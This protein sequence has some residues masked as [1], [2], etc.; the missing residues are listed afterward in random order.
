[1]S[2]NF[3]LNYLYVRTYINIITISWD[4]FEILICSKKQL[5]SRTSRASNII[6]NDVCRLVTLTRES[7]TK[8]S[9]NVIFY[10]VT[11]IQNLPFILEEKNTHKSDLAGNNTVSINNI[12][13]L[14]IINNDERICRLVTLTKDSTTKEAADN[15]FLN[16]VSITQKLLFYLEEKA[17][18]KC[19]LAGNNNLSIYHTTHLLFK[20]H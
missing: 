5:S 1:M 9:D 12:E 19:E 20:D 17:N 18:H 11:I 13:G 16:L 4:H 6:N 7:T 3:I 10:F 8:Q 2:N 14:N 15:I